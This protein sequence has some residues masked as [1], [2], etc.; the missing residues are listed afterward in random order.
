MEKIQV[1]DTLKQEYKNLIGAAQQME[2]SIGASEYRLFKIKQQR[3]QVDV[4]LKAW[5]DKVAEEL[6]LD[7]SNDYYVD[8][9]GA[10]NQVEKPETPA[11]PQEVV[12]TDAVAPAVE[13]APEPEVPGDNKEGGTAADLT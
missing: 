12:D 7:K 13:P 9:E 6:K 4:E 8:A 10:I 1:N 2:Q 3:E 5:W 11:A